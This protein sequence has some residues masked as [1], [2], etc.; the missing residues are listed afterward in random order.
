MRLVSLDVFRGLAIACM[1]AVNMASVADQVYP[2]L[3]HADWHGFTLAD[4]VFPAF[5]FAVGLAMPFSFDK[6]TRD[7]K[8][9]RAVYLRIVRRSLI[10]FLLGLLLNGFWTYDV[11]TLRWMGVLQRISL[12]YL[13]AAFAV[14]HLPRR[15][16]W[17]MLG[18]ILLGYWLLLTNV[19][20]P[21]FGTNLLTRDG[22]LGAY[23]DR[24]IIPKA[25]LYQGD[26]YNGLGDPEGLFSTL[27]AIT[28]VLGGYVTGQ[29][30][31]EQ[32]IRTRTV[33]G[34]VL[35]GIGC[36]LLGGLWGFVFAI[37]K[38]LWTSSYV[39]FSMGWSLILFAGCYAAAELKQA[40]RWVMPLQVLGLNAIA[41]FVL[42]VLAIKLLVKLK[43]GTGDA[44]LSLYDWI[45]QHGFASWAGG[46]AGSLL[47]AIATVLTWW[48]V[49]YGLY[50]R[51]WF[52]KV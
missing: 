23:F 15:G 16:I 14:L 45:Y 13:I 8:P 48:A 29:W 42:S 18:A 32:P 44:A 39:V 28:S 2:F 7:R 5:L 11:S 26:A 27:P 30:V 4:W 19:P 9:T 3:N 49:G 1:I 52:V 21:D 25:H 43:I 24:L 50:R 41:L 51:G 46:E 20:V 34:L 40:R 6:Y 12:T 10:L 22:N 37:N 31:R 35:A 17:V 33:V 38:K 47:L 36:L